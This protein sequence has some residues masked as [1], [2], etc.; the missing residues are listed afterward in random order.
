MCRKEFSTERGIHTEYHQKVS[1]VFA[2][3][4]GK[5]RHFCLFFCWVR[6]WLVGFVFA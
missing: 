6:F 1:E 3:D 2:K 5:L 4:S